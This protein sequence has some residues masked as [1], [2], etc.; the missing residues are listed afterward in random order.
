MAEQEG[1]TKLLH[2]APTAAPPHI[3]VVLQKQE[4]MFQSHVVVITISP[5][6][7]KS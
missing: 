7:R 4:E 2:T 6:W 3:I 1:R 5:L